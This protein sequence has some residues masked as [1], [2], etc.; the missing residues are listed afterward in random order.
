MNNQVVISQ[1]RRSYS[2]GKPPSLILREVIHQHPETTVPDLMKVMQD[3]FSLSYES[4]QCIGGWWA[5]ETGE[6]SDEQLDVFLLR[7]IQ[8]DK[9]YF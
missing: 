9:E 1:I 6:L 5:D 2:N 8:K 4:V 7:A 3:A